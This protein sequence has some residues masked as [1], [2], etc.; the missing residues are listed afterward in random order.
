MGQVYYLS[1]GQ[2]GE[3]I[4]LENQG[5]HVID[6]PFSLDDFKLGLKPFHGEVKGVLT[7]GR[8]GFWHRQRLCR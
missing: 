2:R 6:E 1:T 3:I 7:R 8:L 5:A 4:R